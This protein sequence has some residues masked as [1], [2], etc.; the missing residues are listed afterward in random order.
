MIDKFIDMIKNNG[1]ERWPFLNEIRTTKE[2]KG[3][4]GLS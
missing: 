2:K 1:E 3:K 4:R